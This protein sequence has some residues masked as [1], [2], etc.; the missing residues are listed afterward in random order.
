MLFRSD[1]EMPGL[2]SFDPAKEALIDQRFEDK[3][4]SK[5]FV[6][7][8]NS[9]VRLTEYA[10]NRL[11]YSYTSENPQ[12]IVFSE[13][14]YEKGWQAYLDGQAVPHFRCNYILRGMQVP[15]GA[16]SIEFRFE[17]KAYA[18]TENLSLVALYMLYAWILVYVLYSIWKSYRKKSTKRDERIG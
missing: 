10:P 18:M 9:F 13:I 16:H 2:N 11:L 3:I 17:P 8:S 12:C 5:S 6:R 14:Y 4:A 7:D 15:A 1:E